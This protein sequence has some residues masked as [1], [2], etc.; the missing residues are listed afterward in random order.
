MKKRKRI[1][2]AAV[3]FWFLVLFFF[4]LFVTPKKYK[5][6]I[7]IGIQL[8]LECTLKVYFL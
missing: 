8:A 3:F 6:K 5:N 7:R 2:L 1:N 4:N